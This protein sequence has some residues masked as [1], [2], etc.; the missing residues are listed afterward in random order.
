MSTGS[1]PRTASRGLLSAV[2][3]LA[4]A[5]AGLLW[6]ASSTTW[7]E[8]AYRDTFGRQDAVTADGARLF[9]ELVPIALAALAAV[10]AVLATARWLR[11][12]VGVLV[13]LA[14]GLLVWR[15]AARVLGG[16]L[17]GDRVP[18]GTTPLGRP[19]VH[20]LGALLALAAGVVLLVAGALVLGWAHRLPVMGAKYSAP[21]A[22]KE[23]PKDPDRVLWD[24]LD[25]GRDPTVRDEDDRR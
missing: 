4:L 10:A 11:R 2:V 21:G 24:E 19:E 17:G 9:P 15:V 12:L 5:A 23:R 13:A 1:A 22:A 14:G 20:P 6:G 18:A 25:E 7:V 16:A 8:Q 3:L